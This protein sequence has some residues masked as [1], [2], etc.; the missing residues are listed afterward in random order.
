MTKGWLPVPNPVAFTIGKFDIMW[1]GILM[2]SGVILGFILL[3]LRAKKH[4]LNAD[5]VYDLIICCIPS[6]AICARLYYVIFEWD[7]YKDNL[8]S[9]FDFRAGGLAIH[10][11]IIGGFGLALLLLNKWK[12][13]VAKWIDLAACSLPLAQA[14]ARWGNYFNSEAHGT[15]TNL[16][17]AIYADGQWVHPTFLYESIWCLLLFFFLLWLSESGHQKFDWQITFLYGLLYSLERFF[18]EGLR[19]DSLMI[20][21]FKQAQVLSAVVVVISLVMLI[22]LGKKSK[23]KKEVVA[24]EAPAIEVE[25][26]LATEAEEV[27][28]LAPKE[29][30]TLEPE[31]KQKE[32]TITDAEETKIKE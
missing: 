7:S 32:A 3:Y 18:V 11:A 15:P 9:I 19:T 31:E 14:I 22:I 10:G 13:P 17:W 4:G 24:E 29:M 5:R 25:E 28:A 16:P 2:A 30:S 23:N 6:G 1:Y 26:A 20:G 8:K 27:S 12:E 21:S